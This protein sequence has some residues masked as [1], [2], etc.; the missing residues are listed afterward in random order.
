MACSPF[1][2]GCNGRREEAVPEITDSAKI[3]GFPQPVFATA[4][5]PGA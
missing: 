4:K 3:D 2:I 1:R 5:V